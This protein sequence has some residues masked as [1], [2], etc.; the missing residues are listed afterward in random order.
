M[1]SR[2]ERMEYIQDEVTLRIYRP[3]ERLDIPEGDDERISEIIEAAIP[4]LCALLRQR[5][6]ARGYGFLD[7]SNWT[8]GDEGEEG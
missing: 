2:E 7:V 5:L 4:N 1:K 8:G 3:P 6:S